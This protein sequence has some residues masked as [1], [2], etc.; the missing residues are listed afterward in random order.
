MKY[1]HYKAIGDKSFDLDSAD[2]TKI[3]S[4]DYYQNKLTGTYLIKKVKRKVKQK[5]I[6]LSCTEFNEQYKIHQDS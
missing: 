3:I 5:F 2:K 1:D 4:L 6:Y